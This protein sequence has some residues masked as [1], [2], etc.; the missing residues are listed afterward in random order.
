MQ[1]EIAKSTRVCSYDRAGLG[2]SDP[3]P[4]QEAGS[5]HIVKNLHSL[6]ANAGVNPPYVLVGQS[7]GGIHIRV[8]QSLY[9]VEIWFTKSS[10][11]VH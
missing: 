10:P 6:L 8:Y 4:K 9:P 7:L 2:Y 11:Q 5:R 3:R 1:P